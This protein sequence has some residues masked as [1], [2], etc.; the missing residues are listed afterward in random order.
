MIE[1]IDVSVRRRGALVLD[2]VSFDVRPGQ[3]TG[4]LGLPGAGKTSLLRRMVQIDRGGGRTLFDGLEYRRL[5][6]PLREVG[7]ALDSGIGHPDLTVRDRLRL[8]LA[9]D[10]RAA[11]E[12]G[13]RN[14]PRHRID[15]VLDIVGL[16]DDA[17]TLLRNLSGSMAAR[18][19][20]GAALVGD[21]KT[22]VLDELDRE[23]EPE[24]VAWLGALLRAYTAQGRAALVTSSDT[25]RLLSLADRLL[26][27]DCGALVATR[28]AEEVLR[29]PAGTA[30]VV[31]SPQIVRFAAILQ[32]LGVRTVDGPGASLEVRGLDRARIG[33]LAYRHDIPVHEL[34][35]RRPGS[36]PAD[37]VLA[38][39]CPRPAAHLPGQFYEPGNA[40][41]AEARLARLYRTA[42]RHSPV[43]EP[44][45]TPA[46]SPAPTPAPSRLAD[47]D[48]IP[49]Q[50]PGVPPVRGAFP[51]AHGACGSACGAGFASAPVTSAGST[52]TR[53]T[54][55]APPKPA[56]TP[57]PLPVLPAAAASS[58]MTPMSETLPT[59]STIRPRA[60]RTAPDADPGPRPD[61]A[62]PRHA[63]PPAQARPDEAAG[64]PDRKSIR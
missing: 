39:C 46:S 20:V 55:L 9:A 8:A 26:L 40:S 29:T 11:R 12:R 51:S 25:E 43:T 53:A 57:A 49:E 33:D 41:P 18:L 28:T 60:P 30:V 56:L 6:H 14:R 36:D 7:L 52:T 5:R 31:R 24:G 44:R 37:A 64:R 59:V 21:P 50:S 23:L 61:A 1:A 10:P 2:A 34:A 4:V 45:P 62:S 13:T 22:L 19:A 17:G 35:E 42:P 16:T 47:P 15:A 48:P 32:D 54:T 3:I 58:A 38:S 27:L 63:R